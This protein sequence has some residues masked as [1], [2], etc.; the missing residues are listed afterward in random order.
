MARQTRTPRRKRRGYTV[1]KPGEPGW[2]EGQRPPGSPVH[3][4]LRRAVAL[5][6]ARPPGSPVHGALRRC[7]PVVYGGAVAPGD[8]R[9]PGSPVHGAFYGVAPSFRAGRVWL[10]P[11]G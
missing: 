4:A 3:G 11:P 8:A 1:P 10:E 5:G 7:S 2:A 9:P 6:D